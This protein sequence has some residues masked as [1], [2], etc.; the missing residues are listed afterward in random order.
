MFADCLVLEESEN[1]FIGKKGQV[2]QWRASVR[3][4]GQGQRCTNNL[5]YTL[6]DEEQDKFK[7]K[8]RDKMVRIH[9]KT[10]Y[11]GNNGEIRIEG[12]LEV[13]PEKK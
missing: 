13:L 6:T 7:G 1:S 10:M 9:I 11:P 12:S 3:D 4:M 8:I 2:R 5:V